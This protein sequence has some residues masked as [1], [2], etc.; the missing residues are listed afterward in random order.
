MTIN[1]HSFDALKEGL[2]INY[3]DKNIRELIR[4]ES[5]F[6]DWI[7]DAGEGSFKMK[8]KKGGGRYFA[9][10]LQMDRA[11][12]VNPG[13][14]EG[15]FPGFSGGTND[16]ID[17]TSVEE[18][19]LG[20][21]TLY[22]TI[23]FTSQQMADAH[24]SFEQFKGWGFA[25]HVKAMQDDFRESL[26]YD[27]LSDGTGVLGIITAVNLSGGNTVC[28]LKSADQAD[29]RGVL[30]TQRLKKNQKVAI[31]RAADWATNAR[32]AKIDSNVGDSATAF[33]K[34]V[35]TSGVMDVTTAPTATLSGD[36][37]GAGTALAAGDI[38]VKANSRSAANGGGQA[39]DDSH[40]RCMQGLF[41]WVDDGT[42]N[43]KYGDLTRASYTQVNSQVDLSNALRK[44]TWPRVQ[45]MMDK[46]YRRR[47]SDDKKIEDEYVFFSERGVRTG[48]VVDPGE[49][50]KRYIQEGKAKKLVAGFNDVIMAFVGSD[51][52][53][54]WVALNTHPYGHAS[55]I[56]KGGFE[57]MWDIAPKIVDDDDQTMRNIEGTAKFWM[58][59]Q[60][61]GQIRKLES[62]LD[63]RFSGLEGAFTA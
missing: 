3:T 24:A 34:V 54:P 35:A 51:T 1:A 25:K 17:R 53:M 37:V 9:W 14:E 4:K 46:L 40:L 20:R 39:A 47:G 61:V 59:M 6:L 48:Y 33:Q 19:T 10:S 45:L 5:P 11:M 60:G 56:R 7:E 58:A 41:S 50:A 43:S 29:A 57:I 62:W 8:E 2:R 52:L 12:N 38:I 49:A 13:T 36:L 55:L 26:E 23:A 42:L 44:L 32:L 27:A 18:V 21:A 63:A 22:A 31:I 16:D 30:G 28:T 15:Y